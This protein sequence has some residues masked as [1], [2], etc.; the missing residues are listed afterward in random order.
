MRLGSE[1]KNPGDSSFLEKALD[2]LCV[3]DRALYKVKARILIRSG[4]IPAIASI[5]KRIKHHETLYIAPIKELA[6]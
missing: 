2:K 1:M 4:E 3:I 6:D 5:S